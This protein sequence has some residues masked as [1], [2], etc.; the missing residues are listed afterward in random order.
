[1]TGEEILTAI[2]APHYVTLHFR[3]ACMMRYFPYNSNRR[4]VAILS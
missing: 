3:R 1:M 4:D 2:A